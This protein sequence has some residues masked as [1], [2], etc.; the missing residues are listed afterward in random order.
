MSA[1]DRPPVQA[2]V[3]PRPALRARL[4]AILAAWR[5][6]RD[7][8]RQLSASRSSTHGMAYRMS[9]QGRPELFH[10][11]SVELLPE[12]FVRSGS[13]LLRASAS[14][15]SD[16]FSERV[17]PDAPPLSR[18]AQCAQS[19]SRRPAPQF[20]CLCSSHA[21]STLTRRRRRTASRLWP[22]KHRQAGPRLCRRA[23]QTRSG[24]LRIRR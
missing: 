17:G 13:A 3:N 1:P 22:P 9:R 2:K 12:G 11:K 7:A 5:I 19:R 20:T 10:G 18:C 21:R 15:V 4:L 23:G 24:S 14:K 16:G 8:F 6:A